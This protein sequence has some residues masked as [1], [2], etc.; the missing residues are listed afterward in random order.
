M[1]TPNPKNFDNPPTILLDVDE[2]L[3]DFIGG[4]CRAIGIPRESFVA[5]VY[6]TCKRDMPSTLGMS[7]DAFWE[8]IEALGPSFW[9]RLEWLP[10]AGKLLGIVSDYPWYLITTPTQDP[11]CQLGKMMW[12]ANQFG[13]GFDR[14]FITHHKHMFADPNTILIDDSE[15]NVKEFRK[16]GG[17]AILFPSIVNIGYKLSGVPT[18]YVE[19]QLNALNI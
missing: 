18:M 12:I 19:D 6:G 13:L 14:Y 8:P 2:V 7:P 16:Q 3:V 5:A 4:A 11:S 9:H 1:S 10:W 17:K 15:D